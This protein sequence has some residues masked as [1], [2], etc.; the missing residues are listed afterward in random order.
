MYNNPIWMLWNGAAD[1]YQMCQIVIYYSNEVHDRTGIYEKVDGAVYEDVYQTVLD[2]SK[3]CQLYMNHTL[4]CMYNAPVDP[5][6][7]THT[8]S[9]SEMND[10]VNYLLEMLS[11][12]LKALS[13][14]DQP[15]YSAFK[16]FQDK[17]M[18]MN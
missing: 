4:G 12:L 13:M 18:G 8:L 11:D 10:A 16:K 17:L 14:Y 1:T 6:F 3:H 5:I 2:L 9:N 7:R 15:S